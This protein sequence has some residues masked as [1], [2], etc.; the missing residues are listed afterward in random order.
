MASPYFQNINLQKQD[1][2][3]LQAGGRAMGEAY[4][5]AFNAIGQIG[6]AYFERKSMERKHKRL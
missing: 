6:S 5:S 1:F 3:A 2:S 4:A